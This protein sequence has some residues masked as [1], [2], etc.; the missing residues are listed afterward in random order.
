M[1]GTERKR[2]SRVL[3][4]QDKTESTPLSLSILAVESA[5]T[6]PP[7]MPVPARSSMGS[8]LASCEYVGAAELQWQFKFPGV[9]TASC[10]LLYLKSENVGACTSLI[11]FIQ[12]CNNKK[13][14]QQ[15]TS[16]TL[17][18]LHDFT[19]ESEQDDPEHAIRQREV[20]L[21]LLERELLLEYHTNS[22]H[23]SKWQSLHPLAWARSEE[24]FFW[25]DFQQ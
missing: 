23:I 5:L 16:L 10:W 3:H 17:T 19:A 11:F 14:I 4:K 2:I 24:V 1:L 8:I 12:V 21:D 7:K 6:S 18:S 13:G 22:C 9:Y 20:V 15:E 25:C